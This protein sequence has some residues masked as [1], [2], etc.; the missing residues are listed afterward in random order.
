MP[1]WHGNC[2][3]IVSSNDSVH[4]IRWPGRLSAFGSL[5]L[6]ARTEDPCEFTDFAR[7]HDDR[8]ASHRLTSGYTM[9]L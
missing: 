7:H 3:R 6:L 5:G 4:R 2:V 8:N 9:C 1:F